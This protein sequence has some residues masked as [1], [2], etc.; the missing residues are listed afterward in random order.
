MVDTMSGTAL[1]IKNSRTHQLAK[2]LA[3]RRGTSLTKAVTDALAEALERTP[4]PGPTKLAR[5]LEISERS[6]NLPLLDERSTDDILG[7]DDSGVPR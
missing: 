6:A 3:D 2:E 4:K 5:L 1:N 7:Y